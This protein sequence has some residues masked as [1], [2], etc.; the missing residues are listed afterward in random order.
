M[1]EKIRLCDDTGR[2]IYNWLGEATLF[3]ICRRNGVQMTC[4][5]GGWKETKA[6]AGLLLDKSEFSKL[7]TQQRAE[8]KA[9]MKEEWERTSVARHDGQRDRRQF[10]T[11]D[12]RE[13]MVAKFTFQPGIYFGGE[14]TGSFSKE[15]VFT[16]RSP[17]EIRLHLG[18]LSSTR[19]TDRERFRKR[20][21]GSLTA[22]LNQAHAAFET[23][24]AGAPGRHPILSLAWQAQKAR[25][26]HDFL[27]GV[28][29]VAGGL[30]VHVA[31]KEANNSTTKW[32][33][34][35]QGFREG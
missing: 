32:S 27:V 8:R 16:G 1:R 25:S 18:C 21:G 17:T 9:K 26:M 20:G 5:W 24:G 31:I 10:F 35:S 11:V 12:A 2:M 13:G 7:T 22:T 23:Q 3:D 30:N 4:V 28:R 15:V 29:D 14:D 19:P 6:T 34:Q 33:F